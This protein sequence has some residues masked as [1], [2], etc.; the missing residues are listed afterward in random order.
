M[1]ITSPT[2]MSPRERGGSHL[3]EDV[4]LDLLVARLPDEQWRSA[5]AHLTSCPRCAR[6]FRRRSSEIEHLRTGPEYQALLQEKR[7]SAQASETPAAQTPAPWAPGAEAPAIS[8]PR[9]ADEVPIEERIRRWLS[10]AI[11]RPRYA[12]AA[13]AA[14]AAV[15]VLAIFIVHPKRSS[16]LPS[17]LDWLPS[18]SEFTQLRQV[19]SGLPGSDGE[20]VDRQQIARAHAGLLRGVQAYDRRDLPAAIRELR[21]VRG[22]GSL[23]AFR[24]LYLANALLQR[25]DSDEAVLL[26][27]AIPCENLPDRWRHASQWML[28]VGLNRTGHRADADSL[29]RS[30]AAEPGEFGDRARRLL[31]GN[32]P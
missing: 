21:S 30:L 20:V 8:A 29:L 28:L 1:S 22:A 9:G 5:T 2:S 27:R 17:E 7:Q 14:V 16:R 24:K 13:T 25:G 31:R 12:L 23:E 6:R 15:A 19:G 11:R 10:A 32:G 26:L 3:G 4:L 18:A